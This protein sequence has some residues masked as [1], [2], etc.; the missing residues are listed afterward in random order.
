MDTKEIPR[1]EWR[2]FFDEFSRQHRGWITTVEVVGGDI[3]DQ[4]ETTRLPLAGISA[5]VKASKTTIEIIVGE[6]SV[7]PETRV[8]RIIQA[9]KRVWFKPP[10]QPGDEA[11]EIESED[12]RKTLVIFARIPPEQV[13]RQLPGV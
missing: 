9:P 7:E 13:E 5:E 10:E 3:G 6:R 2:K 12:G 8:T 4:E 1:E 11:V